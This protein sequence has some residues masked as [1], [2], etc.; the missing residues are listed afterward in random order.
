VMF[1]QAWLDQKSSLW[2]RNQGL[3]SLIGTKTTSAV[4]R[5]DCAE[6]NRTLSRIHLVLPFV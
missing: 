5:K 4:T 1:R 3:E 6:F 2:E